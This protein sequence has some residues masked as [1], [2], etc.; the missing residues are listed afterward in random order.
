M[1]FP[2]RW[3]ASVPQPVIGNRVLTWVFDPNDSSNVGAFLTFV[4][5]KFPNAKVVSS[6]DLNGF[7]SVTITQTSDSASADCH[8]DECLS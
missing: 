5:D 1:T 4:K 6:K 3:P 7:T 2:S 8:G